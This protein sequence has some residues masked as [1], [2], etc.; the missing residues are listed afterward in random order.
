MWAKHLIPPL[1]PICQYAYDREKGKNGSQDNV[2]L[3]EFING[4]P[5]QEITSQ[6][7]EKRPNR[8]CGW[9]KKGLDAEPSH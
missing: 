6:E 1:P 4:T 3:R 8:E 5:L 7:K 2:Y 9:P